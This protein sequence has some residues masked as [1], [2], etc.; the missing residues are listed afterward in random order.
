MTAYQPPPGI[1]AGTSAGLAVLDRGDGIV[2]AC[3]RLGMLVDHTANPA[4]GAWPAHRAPQENCGRAD[5]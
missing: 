1:T 2:D 4:D 5:Q 3:R